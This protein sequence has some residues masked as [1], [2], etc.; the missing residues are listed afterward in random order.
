MQSF[1]HFQIV[2]WLSLFMFVTSLPCSQAA[3]QELTVSTRDGQEHVGQAL[4]KEILLHTSIASVSFPVAEVLSLA[5]DHRKPRLATVRT[6]SGNQLTGFL[7]HP[8]QLRSAEG[9]HTEFPPAAIERI[10][11]TDP[12]NPEVSFHDSQFLILNN[13]DILSGRIQTETFEWQIGSRTLSYSLQEIETIQFKRYPAT[14]NLLLQDGNQHN[15]QLKSETISF[16]TSWGETVNLSPWEIATLYCRSGFIPTKVRMQIG[17]PNSGLDT[18]Q[19]PE[20]VFE[21]FRWIPPGRFM[22]GSETSEQGRGSD[23]GPQTEVILTQGFWMAECEVTQGEYE[24]LIG[25]NPSTFQGNAQWP[26]EKVS[27]H[28]AMAYCHRLTQAATENET[29]PEGYVFR[30]PTEAEWE[31]ACRA[32]SVSRFSYGDDPSASEMGRYGWYV[33]NSDSSPHPVKQLEPNPWGL[34]DMH[35]NVWEWCYDLWQY[36]YPGGRQR[37]WSARSEG[38]LRVARGGSWLYSADH[39]R[40]ANRDDYG[41]NNRCSDIGFRVVLARALP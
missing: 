25:S 14:V 8:F 3:A 5:F 24:Q 7:P 39:S 6:R 33:D 41:P 15:G 11:S 12:K 26:V 30:L 29:L 23:E 36:A 1:S 28:E 4:T 22:M 19:E 32:G 2:R 27:W 17:D 38:W 21:G 35:G 10:I 18:A 20:L 37:D 9:E 13:G 40:S 16:A 34:Y 31:Y